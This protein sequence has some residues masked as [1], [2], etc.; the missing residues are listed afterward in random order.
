MIF[1]VSDQVT[2][3][4]KG[5]RSN[6]EYPKKEMGETDPEV[7]GGFRD[8]T[9]THSGISP[10]TRTLPLSWRAWTLIL[11]TRDLIGTSSL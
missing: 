6:Y 11:M 9:E 5:P 8:M 4:K 1:T 3:A 10:L 2:M 7:V